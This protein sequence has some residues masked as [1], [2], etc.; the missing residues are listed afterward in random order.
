[1]TIRKERHTKRREQNKILCQGKGAKNF[2]L[3]IVAY[4][5]DYSQKVV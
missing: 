1:M 5:I 2:A 4:F 3:L